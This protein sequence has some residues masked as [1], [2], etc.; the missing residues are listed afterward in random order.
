MGITTATVMASRTVDE[1][2]LV[3]K[4]GE[5]FAGEQ[6]LGGAFHGQASWMLRDKAEAAD[7]LVVEKTFTLDGHDVVL[8][9]R[10]TLDT[11]GRLQVVTV[12]NGLDKAADI[13]EAGGR[14]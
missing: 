12:C 1:T 6:K 5:P 2:A 11:N 3:F 8:E 9:E 4:V 14:L 13:A 7:T 10:Y